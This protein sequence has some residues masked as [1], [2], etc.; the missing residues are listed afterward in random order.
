MRW[1]GQAAS[2]C[3]AEVSVPPTPYT[4]QRLLA[5][6]GAATSYPTM[7]LPHLLTRASPRVLIPP[8]ITCRHPS[9]ETGSPSHPTPR[10]LR[11]L[12]CA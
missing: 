4:R 3:P 2:D 9:P 11:S 10:G 7:E 8:Q 6:G 12:R 1:A 5:Q